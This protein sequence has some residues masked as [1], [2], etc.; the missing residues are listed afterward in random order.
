MHIYIFGSLVRGD[1]SPGSDI[2]LLAIVDGYDPRFEPETFSIYS[3]NRI[4]ALWNEGN[5]FAWHLALE[6]KLIYSSEGDDF[7]GELG[8]PGSYESCL[9]DC[10][11]FFALFCDASNSLQS[12]TNSPVFALSSVFLSI[13]NFA[14][15][16]SLGMTTAP[17]FSRSSALE[18]D[19]ESIPISE[20][21][22][23]ILE[24]ARILCTRGYGANVTT[25]E[26]A[27]V[28]SELTVIGAWMETLL[29]K[30]R[31]RVRQ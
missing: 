24:S 15:C 25:S 11:K 9:E 7:L 28:A 23:R 13:R 29:I 30:I 14:T 12:N 21:S 20:S 31:D 2:D 27:T 4:R 1:V 19:V 10:G 8:T 6:S 5:A 16:F 26:A 3:Y 17:T 22:Y 18:L